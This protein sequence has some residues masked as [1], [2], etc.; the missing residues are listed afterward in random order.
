MRY[1][2]IMTRNVNG[3]CTLSTYVQHRQSEAAEGEGVE[4]KR[5]N[6]NNNNSTIHAFYSVASKIKASHASIFVLPITHTLSLSL[7]VSASHPFWK[8]II[9]NIITCALPVFVMRLN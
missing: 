3:R 4:K 1:E 2:I 8:Q 7:F 5:K 6:E 9:I